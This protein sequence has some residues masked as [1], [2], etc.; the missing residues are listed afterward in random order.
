MNLEPTKARLAAATPGP[1][2]HGDRYHTAGA[3]FMNRPVDKCAYCDGTRPLVFS[4]R[5]NIN[6]RMMMAHTHESSTPWSET[7]I[8]HFDGKENLSVV[9]ETDEYGLMN[10]EDADLIAHAPTDLAELVAEVERLRAVID[11][12]ELEFVMWLYSD[13][14]V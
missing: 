11:E 9:I 12:V 8:Y 5:M 1:W 7:G 3:G 14:N 10:D 13:A 2:E 4:G 6:G